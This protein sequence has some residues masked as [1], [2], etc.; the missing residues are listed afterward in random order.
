M[1]SERTLENERDSNGLQITFFKKAAE[2]SPT[3]NVIKCLKSVKKCLQAGCV[4][5][6]HN[7]YNS[8]IDPTSSLRTRA[9]NVVGM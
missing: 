7:L 4:M 9:A 2:D 5:N 6:K 1:T 8:L 3:H